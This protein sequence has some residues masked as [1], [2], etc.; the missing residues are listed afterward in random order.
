MV[1][2]SY[3]D[4]NIPLKVITCNAAIS[5]CE[6]GRKWEEALTLLWAARRSGVEPDRITYSSALGAVQSAAP[7]D[8]RVSAKLREWPAAA[9][10]LEAMQQ[11]GLE[12][13]GFNYGS[14][15]DTS[16][17]ADV[18]HSSTSYYIILFYR[19]LYIIVYIIIIRY[20]VLLYYI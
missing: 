20:D 14:V 6:K 16:K 7:D 19:T 4:L 9:A 15:I 5:A 11:A 17:K 18:L 10:L 2:P 1:C 3:G 12:A 8:G 13:S